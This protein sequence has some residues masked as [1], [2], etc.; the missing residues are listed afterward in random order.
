LIF[1]GLST[2]STP[3]RSFLR[4]LEDPNDEVRKLTLIMM[5]QG[6]A[7]QHINKTLVIAAE[8]IGI[9]ARVVADECV[10]QLNEMLS[11]ER[12]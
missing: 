12:H 2:V 3:S 10:R 11:L 7:Y 6:L 5:A 8:T 4:L 1:G 9:D